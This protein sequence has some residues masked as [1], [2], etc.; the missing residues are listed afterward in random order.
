VFEMGLGRQPDAG[1]YT[2]Y[3]K[4]TDAV[5]VQSVYVSGER[6]QRN[7]IIAKQ[8]T[9]LQ[10]ALTNEQNKPPREVVK[11]VIKIVERP[12]E[13]IKEVIKEVPAVVD[14]Q[15]IVQNVFIRFWKSL[16]KKG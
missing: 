11:E 7:S 3:R 10:T 14:E 16:F 4:T 8:L 6:A 5:L 12:T 9:D 15:E 2:T 13:V 1:A